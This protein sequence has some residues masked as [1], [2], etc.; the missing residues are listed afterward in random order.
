MMKLNTTIRSCLLLFILLIP[1]ML[2]INSCGKPEFTP[3]Y[4]HIDSVGLTT[5]YGNDGSNSHFIPDAWVYVDNQLVGDFELPA[6]VPVPY[7][8]NHTIQIQGGVLE[9]G[10]TAE[11]H[12]YPF[13][14]PYTTN[15]NL[16]SAG[17][18]TL[19]PVVTYLASAY[20]FDWKEDFESIGISMTFDT[21]A[22]NPKLI[23]DTL[24][25]FEGH[26]S[27]T[28]SFN[29][30]QNHFQCLSSAIFTL[31]VTGVEVYLE[32]NYLTNN[33]F[34]VG[35]MNSSNYQQTT[36]VSVKPNTVW[37][38]M[39]IRLTDAIT[40]TGVVTGGTYQ[41]YIGMDRDPL[42]NGPQMHIDNIKLIH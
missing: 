4:I 21:N 36:F 8:G 32:L 16:V 28:V 38:K 15:L 3:T 29:T 33:A 40:Q 6:T 9:S 37:K 34:Y 20:P 10:S 41:V 17:K 25:P 5:H 26:A 1:G 13:Y 18:I 35:V 24:H 19:K 22:V 2:I 31:P 30:G 12:P 14:A 23:K 27:G 11:R 7:S 39:Y 42:V